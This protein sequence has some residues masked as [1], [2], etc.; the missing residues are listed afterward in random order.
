[1]GLAREGR[2][3]LLQRGPTSTPVIACPSGLPIASR[4]MS[5]V[6]ERLGSV[7]IGRNEGE[8]LR[9]C[10]TSLVGQCQRVVYVDSGS[11]DG[12]IELAKGLGCEVVSLDLSLPFTAARGRNAGL[13][14]LLELYPDTEVVQFVDGDCEV[15]DGWLEA[16]RRTLAEDPRLAVVCGWRRERHPEA[17]IYNTYCEVEW[18]GPPGEVEFCGGDAMMRVSALREVGGFDGSLIAGEEP[19]LCVRLRQK[20]WRILRLPMDMTLHDAAMTRFTQWWR[21]TQRAGFA[22]AQGAARHGHTPERHW[23]EE[24]RR[25]WKWG[26][27]SAVAVGAAVPTLG[28]S[29]L[30]LSSYPL[31]AARNFVRTRREGRSMRESLVWSGLCAVGKLAELQGALRYHLTDGR[32]RPS[33]IIEYKDPAEA[34]PPA[35]TEERAASDTTR[36]A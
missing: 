23:V 8:R 10:L 9:L 14:R 29:L 19:D 6:L 26:A 16:G 2:R 1:M 33:R 35:P 17:S 15:V 20:G 32:G 31:S 3:E 27:L 5:S 24:N 34:A 22:Y 28:G 11:T 30:L 13:E 18:R 4:V 36:A 21:R 25:I 7:A 12:S